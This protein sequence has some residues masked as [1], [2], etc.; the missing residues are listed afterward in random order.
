MCVGFDAKLK[1]HKKV[2][3]LSSLFLLDLGHPPSECPVFSCIA[4]GSFAHNWFVILLG[5]D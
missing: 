1:E 2:I 4:M 3:V 5:G